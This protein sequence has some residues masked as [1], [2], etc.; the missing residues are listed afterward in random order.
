MMMVFC[1]K[2]QRFAINAAVAATSRGLTGKD[3]SR[4]LKDPIFQL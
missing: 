1:K 2:N 3:A 4:S